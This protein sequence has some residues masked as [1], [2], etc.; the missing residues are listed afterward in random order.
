MIK[1][2]IYYLFVI[3]L[4]F[5]SFSESNDFKKDSLFLYNLFYP[6][7]E[8]SK[9]QEKFINYITDYLKLL[10]I[11]YKIYNIEIEPE[12]YTN[13]Q[14]IEINFKAKNPT[15]DNI[16]ILTSLNTPIINNNYFDNSISIEIMLNLI[17]FYSKVYLKKNI[18]F[19]FIGSIGKEDFPM[20][21]LN[22]FLDKIENYSNSLVTFIDILNINS[23][24]YFTGSINKKPIPRILIKIFDSINKNK[25]ILLDTFEIKRAKLN[26]L[27]KREYA[28]ICNLRGVLTVEFSNRNKSIYNIFYYKKDQLIKY[29]NFFIAWINKLNDFNLNFEREYNYLYENIFGYKFF[30]KERD[31]IIIFLILIFLTLFTRFF[32]PNFQNLRIITFLKILPYFIF[33]FLCYFILN[34]VPFIFLSIINL[35]YNIEIFYLKISLLLYYFIIFYVSFLILV[36][37]INLFKKFYFLRHSYIYTIGAILFSYLNLVLLAFL[38][39]SFA[40]IF[41]WAIIFITLS[42]FTGRNYILKFVFYFLSAFPFIKFIFDF[43]IVINIKKDIWN[44]YIYNLIFCI[45]SFPFL[46]LSIRVFLIIK[47]KLNTSFSKKKLFL[48]SLIVVI[49]SIT[50]FFIISSNY[51]REEKRINVK[52]LM[53][54]T[55][56]DYYFELISNRKLKEFT[57]S[58][59]N[60]IKNI[61]IKDNIIKIP[62]D[63]IEKGHNIKY[64]KYRI[65]DYSKYEINITSERDIELADI[66]LY[67]PYSAYIF[68]S[69]YP[70]TS[71][72]SE[73]EF[74]EESIFKINIARNPGKEINLVFTTFKDIKLKIVFSFKYIGF[75]E[76]I[77]FYNKNFTIKKEKEIIDAIFID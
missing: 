29:T 48:F 66:Y 12:F 75:S 9:N 14:I 42:N 54:Y 67:L 62:I 18:T 21:G 2:Y 70:F 46:L 69:N 35:F 36:I 7:D 58:I 49:L 17:E 50:V 34:S 28:S 57:Y 56:N 24:V 22:N 11:D 60:E 76:N 37:I 40:Y 13:S 53:N 33:L 47:S 32:F 6:R 23:P 31:L 74:L 1:K 52:L 71:L 16:I 64:K 51:E 15:K 5:Y 68:N 8:G 30:I 77:N 72:K 10:N 39:I 63:K 38:D 45:T 73:D 20:Y 43:P 26:L 44:I 3:L 4:S 55:N 19:A 25:E 65:K 59:N 41:I 61:N 27:E